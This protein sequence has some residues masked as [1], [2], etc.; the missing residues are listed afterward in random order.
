MNNEVIF[1][2]E[3][4]QAV[5]KISFE[6]SDKS[7]YGYFNAD[8]VY[9]KL[10]DEG[11]FSCAGESYDEE[12]ITTLDK[13]ALGEYERFAKDVKLKKE[14]KLVGI[15]R[16]EDDYTNY[17]SSRCRNGGAYSYHSDLYI[18]K[19][20]DGRIATILNFFDSSDWSNL[21]NGE[22]LNDRN[23]VE[24]VR[25][26]EEILLGMNI[27]HVTNESYERF[28]EESDFDTIWK[29]KHQFEFWLSMLECSYKTSD[30][31]PVISRVDLSALEY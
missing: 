9:L 16:V 19:L 23:K 8:G 22:K 3:G 2:I 27:S 7:Y 20:K 21:S 26:G 18:F 25:F 15:V 24:F 5:A 4:N 17:D 29:D 28:W 1:R 30:E 11:D 12:I 13:M 10:A 6:G 31:E 14:L